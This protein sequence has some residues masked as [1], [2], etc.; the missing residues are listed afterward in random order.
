MAGGELK[1]SFTLSLVANWQGAQIRA[2][3]SSPCEAF[4]AWTSEIRAIKYGYCATS[5]MNAVCSGD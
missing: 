3:T 1:I 5:A 4:T 2:G